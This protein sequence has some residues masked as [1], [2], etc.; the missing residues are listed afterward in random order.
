MLLLIKM[1]L[2]LHTPMC[3]FLSHPSLCVLVYKHCNSPQDAFRPIFQ[4]SKTYFP[5]D[6]CCCAILGLLYLC[7]LCLLLAVMAHGWYKAISSPLLY[8]VSMSS[9]VCSLLIA[10][11]YLVGMTDVLIHTALAF[12]LCF[13]GSNEIN[14]F[15][16]DLPTRFLLSH[17]GKWISVIHCFWFYWTEHHFRSPFLL[18]LHHPINL[19]HPLYW[20]GVQSFLHPH[21][22]FKCCDN[23]LGNC[24]FL[25]FPAKYFLLSRSR[26]N[27]LIVL[28]PCDSHVKP[29]L[30]SLQNKVVKQALK[31]WKMKGGFKGCTINI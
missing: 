24:T 15:F 28:H 18:L 14:H 11:V 20:G 26:Q 1:D 3:S 8:A 12:C 29:L 30:Y 17:S 2:Q 4:D 19:E 22:S 21:L 13:C 9:R 31:N 6:G 23:F 10:G 25:V 16:C 5:F 27:D 7:R